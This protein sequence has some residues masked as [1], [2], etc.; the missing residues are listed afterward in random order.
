MLNWYAIYENFAFVFKL[1]KVIWVLVLEPQDSYSCVFDGHVLVLEVA[2]LE[3]AVLDSSTVLDYQYL[4]GLFSIFACL[5][6][7]GY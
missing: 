1:P 6:E 4:D 7:I 5:S 2:V 3:V